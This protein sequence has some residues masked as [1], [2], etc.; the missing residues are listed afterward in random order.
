MARTDMPFDIE[1]LESIAV[2]VLK[3]KFNS[4]NSSN[5]DSFKI[6]PA[7]DEVKNI[8][9]YVSKCSDYYHIKVM[10]V[11]DNNYPQPVYTDDFKTI[12]EVYFFANEVINKD[13]I[14]EEE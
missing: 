12:E 10:Q 13:T 1:K 14:I 8:Y 3:T 9:L 6:L 2:G 7:D 5:S 4:A 11:G